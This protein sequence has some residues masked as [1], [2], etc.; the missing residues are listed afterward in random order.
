[1]K[2]HPIQHAFWLIFSSRLSQGLGYHGTYRWRD[3]RPYGM[4]SSRSVERRIRK[5]RHNHNHLRRQRY[6]LV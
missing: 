6:L 5:L 4:W 2:K 1:M 3:D